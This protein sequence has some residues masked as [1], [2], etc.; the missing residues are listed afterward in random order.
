MK[1]SLLKPNPSASED[2]PLHSNRVINGPNGML[3]CNDP[4]GRRSDLRTS[5]KSD[6]PPPDARV[7][8]SDYRVLDAFVFHRRITDRAALCSPVRSRPSMPTS[9]PPWRG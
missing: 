6:H 9:P 8:S 4:A 7:C 2:L 5:F 3:N 1:A